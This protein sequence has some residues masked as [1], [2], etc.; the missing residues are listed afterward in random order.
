MHQW[1]DVI[2][3]WLT[4]SLVKDTSLAS[5]WLLPVVAHHVGRRELLTLAKKLK[6]LLAAV[7]NS[8]S[9]YTNIDNT[10]RQTSFKAS[11][12]RAK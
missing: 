7:Q 11:W 2:G 8:S 3:E 1:E 12:F 10:N 9:D 6:N 5:D 4:S